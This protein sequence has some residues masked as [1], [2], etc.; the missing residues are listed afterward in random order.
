MT[1]DINAGLIH[2]KHAWLLLHRSRE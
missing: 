1:L 2:S